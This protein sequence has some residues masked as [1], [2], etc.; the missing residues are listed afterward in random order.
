MKS[1]RPDKTGRAMALLAIVM[2]L[3]LWGTCLAGLRINGTRSFP[4]GLYWA[5]GRAPK[6]GDL[7]FVDPPATS[8][9]ELAR[10][11]GYLDVGYSQAGSC[12]LIKRLAAAA[13]DRVTIACKRMFEKSWQI[14]THGTRTGVRPSCL[15]AGMGK[16]SR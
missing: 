13:G 3:A 12:A 1:L 7:V 8:I 10:T 2:L 15:E 5:V 4:I 9:F 11:R 14:K 6:K 16:H